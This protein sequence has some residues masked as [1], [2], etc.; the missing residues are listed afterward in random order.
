M[1]CMSCG[2]QHWAVLLAAR[3]GG[4]GEHGS[5]LPV[6]GVP[7]V[8]QQLLAGDESEILYAAR[9]LCQS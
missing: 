2:S 9:P 4:L 8:L 3:I 1:Q 6:V 5:F 7:D